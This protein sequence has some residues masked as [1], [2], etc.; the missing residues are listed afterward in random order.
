MSTTTQKKL[1][2]LENREPKRQPNKIYCLDLLANHV[3]E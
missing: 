1:I 2:A 3:K